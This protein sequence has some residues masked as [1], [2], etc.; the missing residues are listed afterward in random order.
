MSAAHQCQPD[1]SRDSQRET[2]RLGRLPL[3][4][5]FVTA[6]LLRAGYGGLTL[7]RADDPAHLA[8]PDEQQ[9]WMMAQSLYAGGLL[10]DELGFNATRMPLYPA[11]LSLF[12][13]Q[14]AAGVIAAK[15]CHWFLGAA[16]AVF[17]ALLGARC[18][19]CR[20]GLLA[21]LLVAVDLPLVGVSSLLL[22]E[23]P[24]V[25]AL[26]ALWWVGWPLLDRSRGATT[27]RWVAVGALSTLCV[28]IRPSTAG[29]IVLWLVFLAARRGRNLRAWLG[30]GL[31][32]G[33]VVG[34]LVPWAAR[35]HRVTGHWCW[36]THRLGI[37][38][39]D[40]V[41][42]QAT[43]AGDLGNIKA[44]AE[45][46]EFDEV[47]WNDWFMRSS[48]E[49]IRSD[50]GRT[51][52]LAGVKLARTWSPVLHAEEYSSPAMRLIFAGWSAPFFAL[53][54]AG[55][56]MLRTRPAICIA[57]LLPALYLSALH[58]LFV[59]SVRYRLG[60]TPMLAVL[61]AWAAMTAWD[62]VRRK[63]SEQG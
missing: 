48:W 4:V 45:V 17:A 15:V 41:G 46:V 44:M 35:N 47:G 21:G 37:S 49:A 1:P 31:A 18:A 6:L 28:Y 5:V 51:L 50:P 61:A 63:R 9:Y 39:Y 23:A 7:V 58:S 55:T 2:T 56:V 34:S 3:T 38:L 32:L 11:I 8:F 53:A 42:P 27:G 54:I 24:S 13:G 14:E 29:L 25:T 52:K 20:V 16:A 57:L 30:A 59:G 36:L 26:A 43:G 19:G 12:V 60:A 33:I 10:T 62:R 22:T 40:G